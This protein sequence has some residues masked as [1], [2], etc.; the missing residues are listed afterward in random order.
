MDESCTK[1]CL[2]YKHERSWI[3]VVL[4]L[5]VGFCSYGMVRLVS[6]SSLGQSDLVV[7]LIF[8][9][10]TVLAVLFAIALYREKITIDLQRGVVVL[11]NMLYPTYFF[12]VL[13]KRRA[14]IPLREIVSVQHVSGQ[15][16]K[17]VYT[18]RGRFT[19]PSSDEFSEFEQILKEA[20]LN[21]EHPTS[22]SQKRNKW[23]HYGVLCVMLLLVL[24]AVAFLVWP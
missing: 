10:L 6:W 15:R 7:V 12:D 9:V 11:Q 24:G 17:Y 14:E 16:F 21:N 20:A 5:G 2:E 8:A 4:V 23:Y 13:I 1:N 19:I 3:L 22:S 18:T